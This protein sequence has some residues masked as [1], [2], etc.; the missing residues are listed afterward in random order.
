MRGPLL[1]HIRSAPSVTV[2]RG[3]VG[4]NGVGNG[5]IDAFHHKQLRSLI[6]IHWLQRISNVKLYERCRCRQISTCA[7]GVRW[8]LFNH[9][10]RLDEEAPALTA[11]FQTYGLHGYRGRPRTGLRS[12]LDTDLQQ[13]GMRLKTRADLEQLPR[14]ANKTKWRKQHRTMQEK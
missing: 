8:R 5:K 10:L 12:A 2:Q 1:F 9:I 11:Y 6:G 7:M 14:I 3:C 4:P 13:V